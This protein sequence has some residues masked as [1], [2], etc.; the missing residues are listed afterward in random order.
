VSLL[1]EELDNQAQV[2][3]LGHAFH[4]VLVSKG[5]KPFELC[6][7]LL[8]VFFLAV[9]RTTLEHLI[10]LVLDLKELFDSEEP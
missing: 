1:L 7:F 4:E 8:L 10:D 5:Q 6:S 2:D 9:V 3:S